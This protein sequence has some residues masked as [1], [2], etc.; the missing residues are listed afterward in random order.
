MREC[1]NLWNT[2]LYVTCNRSIL[3]VK[4]KNNAESWNSGWHSSINS[5][6]A[7]TPALTFEPSS[8]KNGLT[9]VWYHNKANL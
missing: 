4:N 8:A 5:L 6:A 7:S 3:P 9:I 2:Q 1:K